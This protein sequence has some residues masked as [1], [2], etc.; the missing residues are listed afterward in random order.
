MNTRTSTQQNPHGYS[1][2]LEQLHNNQIPKS[3]PWD[4]KAD[5]QIHLAYLM[6]ECFTVRSTFVS[7]FSGWLFHSSNIAT[8]RQ[9]VDRDSD[10][11]EFPVVEPGT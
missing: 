5:K 11:V 2:M 3:Q 10:E 1:L 4:S 6:T 8:S 9:T 7:E